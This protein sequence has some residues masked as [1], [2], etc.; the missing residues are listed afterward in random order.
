MKTWLRRIVL[1]ALLAGLGFWG[2]RALFPSPE[3]V[4][5]QRLT[6]LARDASFAANEGALAKLANAQT[7]TSFCTP[8]VV[9]TVNTPG[10]SQQTLNG[11]DELLQAV[12]AARASL[13]GLN[14]EF[15]DILVTVAPDGTSAVANLTARGRVPEER[16][17]YVQELEF[18]LRKAE[19]EWLIF[20]VE[21]VKTLSR[22]RQR[23]L[24]L[25]GCQLS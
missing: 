7:L 9:I 6:E 23:E 10:R 22:N 13:R 5:R 20:R 15:F 19:G 25:G 8:D 21:T 16:D 11:R 18:K 14:V 3:H 4:I 17:S 2:W 12:M 1:A 24:K